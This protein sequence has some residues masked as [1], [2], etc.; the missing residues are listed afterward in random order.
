MPFFTVFSTTPL[1]G[2]MPTSFHVSL[3]PAEGSDAR[4]FS[5]SGL[6]TSG[7]KVPTKMNVKSPAS[8]NRS[9]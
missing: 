2:A 7:V 5:T 9:L 8:A 4:Y 1:G 6:M 3:R